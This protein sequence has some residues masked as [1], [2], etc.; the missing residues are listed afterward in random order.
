MVQLLIENYMY[1]RNHLTS[2]IEMTEEQKHNADS[3]SS[4]QINSMFSFTARVIKLCFQNTSL[5]YFQV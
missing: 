1:T 2:T 3:L 5:F 4:S